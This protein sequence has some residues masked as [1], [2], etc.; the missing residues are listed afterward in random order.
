M[1]LWTKLLADPSRAQDSARRAEDEGWDGATFTDSQNYLGE[2]Y[3]VLTAA[4]LATTTLRLATGVTNP[5]TR[6][7]SVTA[8]AAAALASGDGEARRLNAASSVVASPSSSTSIVEVSSLN[9]RLHAPRPV[10]DF[11]VRTRS[12][13]SVSRCLR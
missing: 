8:A 5:L 12:S 9:S 6:H 13:G 10:T 11:S 4:A 3:V 1:E 7:P 2:V